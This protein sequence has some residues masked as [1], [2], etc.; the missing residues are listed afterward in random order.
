MTTGKTITLN[1]QTFAIIIFNG[2]GDHKSHNVDLDALMM[3]WTFSQES[4]LLSMSDQVVF[5]YANFTV[6]WDA[7]RKEAHCGG[8]RPI[9]CMDLSVFIPGSMRKYEMKQTWKW[10]NKNM[11]KLIT[12]LRASCHKI[13]I[14]GAETSLLSLTYVNLIY[15]LYEY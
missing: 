3:L 2:G 13:R 6:S 15:K 11:L 1:R 12:S 7:P 10:N 4:H 14:L 9:P 8:Q 5:I